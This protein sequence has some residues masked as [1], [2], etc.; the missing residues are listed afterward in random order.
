MKREYYM[1]GNKKIEEP[2][3]TK[4]IPVQSTQSTQSTSKPQPLKMTFTKFVPVSKK[5]QQDHPKKVQ[6]T[7][8]KSMFG[9]HEEIETDKKK[10]DKS[11][12]VNRKTN[13]H[14]AVHNNGEK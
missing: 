1:V 10:D 4:S 3:I 7:D 2:K 12:K 14:Y 13:I 8:L 9:S 6:E 11:I 5:T